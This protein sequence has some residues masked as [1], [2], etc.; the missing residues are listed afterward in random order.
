MMFCA[1]NRT[2]KR[3]A[4]ALFNEGLKS[5]L[6]GVVLADLKVAQDRRSAVALAPGLRRQTEGVQISLRLATVCSAR[7]PPIGGDTC[8]FQPNAVTRADASSVPPRR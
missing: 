1:S 3:G 2:L 8:S 4:E 6:D 7:P 5:R